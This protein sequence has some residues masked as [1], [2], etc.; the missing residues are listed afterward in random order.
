M[1]Y[2]Y[3]PGCTLRTKAKDLDNYARAAAKALGI[4]VCNVPGYSTESV[5]QTG[6]S[7]LLNLAGSLY[8]YI[9]STSDGDWKK[10][11][12]FTYFPFRMTE[13]YGKTLGILGYGT[14][15]KRVGEV[16]SALG[17]KVVITSRHR[18]ENCPFPQLSLE[19]ML[20]LCDFLSLN[21][22]LTDETR[23]II[24][25]KTLSLMKPTAFIINT[26]RGP[27]VDEYAAGLDKWIK[28]IDPEQ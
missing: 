19:E 23:M 5:V 22:Q 7:L 11:E 26:S 16:S 10:S 20:P 3:Y 2:S 17:M 27:V 18:K 1:K 21:C 14:I 28:M 8:K 6:F 25:E 13:L 4:T 12:H 24:N 15:G 9:R